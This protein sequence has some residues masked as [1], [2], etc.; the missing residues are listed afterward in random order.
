MK[1]VLLLALSTVGFGG[2]EKALGK[3]KY[4]YEKDGTKITGYYQLE[5]VPQLLHNYILKHEQQNLDEIITLCTEKVEKEF[6]DLYYDEGKN[7]YYNKKTEESNKMTAYS[8]FKERME[9]VLREPT[10]E[11]N[12]F[13]I[14]TANPEKGISQAVKR[15]RKLNQ[16]GDLCLWLD[17]H[18][19]LR[20][21]QMVLDAIVFLLKKEGIVPE[22]IFSVEINNQGKGPSNIISQKKEFDIFNFVSGM[23]EFFYYGKTKG[24]KE[25]FK[26]KMEKDGQLKT[27]LDIVGM[28]AQA[29]QWCDMEEFRD[30]IRRLKPEIEKYNSKENNS[31]KDSYLSVFVEQ[32]K[33]EYGELLE[34]GTSIDTAAWCRKKEFYQQALTVIESQ[35]PEEMSRDKIFY[36]EEKEPADCE[37]TII[38]ATIR[39]NHVKPC[40]HILEQYIYKSFKESLWEKKYLS[41]EVDKNCLKNVFIKKYEIK[42]SLYMNFLEKKSNN[43]NEE[44]NIH[45]LTKV[46]EKDRTKLYQLLFLHMAIK[47]QRNITNHA[48]GKEDGG[49]NR[50][51][52]GNLLAAIDSYIALYRELKEIVQN[53]ENTK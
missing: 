9:K 34:S 18:G 51:E 49:A 27:L 23:Q 26:D 24:L 13:D 15:I 8:F 22:D 11:I 31:E 52:T 43:K 53:T 41:N 37:A 46:P 25:Y 32:M 3:R 1:N 5:P 2:E 6:F 19:G 29:I 45:I 50:A 30:Q 38:S 4:E 47:K 44:K 39:K 28:T 17:I 36:F 12:H 33:N 7:I 40:N 10:P 16:E 48:L 21:M 14:T 20:G 42:N 35:M